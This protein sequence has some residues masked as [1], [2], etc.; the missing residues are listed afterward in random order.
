VTVPQSGGSQDSTSSEPWQQVSQKL[1][2]ENLELA[3]EI[4]GTGFISG[5][6]S[7]TLPYD[8][9]RNYMVQDIAFLHAY[10]AIGKDIATRP[11][12]REL[13][14]LSSQLRSQPISFD[15]YLSRLMATYKVSEPER[16]VLAPAMASYVGYVRT[17]GIRMHPIYSAIIGAAC[18]RLWHWLATNLLGKIDPGNP[19]FSWV[20]EHSGLGDIV[21]SLEQGIDLSFASRMPFCDLTQASDVYRT[22]LTLERQ[23]FLAAVD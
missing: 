5:M 20:Q 14:S 6:A 17:T 16:V 8:I 11:E 22:T 19:Y 10:L 21:K 3:N 12:V 1:W 18:C 23:A 7:G 2:N 9:H 4:S 15:S 13:S